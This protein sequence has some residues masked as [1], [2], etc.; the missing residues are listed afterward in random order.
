MIT[1]KES[2]I[3]AESIPSISPDSAT[4]ADAFLSSQ[5]VR[6]ETKKTYEK[7]L[8]LFLTW[9]QENNIQSPNGETLIRYK[10]TLMDQRICPTTHSWKDA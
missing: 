10:E 6:K 2:I 4:L 7:G 9:L 1:K 8:R 5:D 3:K